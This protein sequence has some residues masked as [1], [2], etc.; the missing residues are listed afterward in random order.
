MRC[1]LGLLDRVPSDFP[2]LLQAHIRDHRQYYGR[3]GLQ[4]TAPNDSLPT[5][6]RMREAR[7]AD[8]IA[9]SMFEQL[10]HVG[11]YL[12]VASG[13]PQPTGS[14]PKSPINLQGIWNQ[15]RRPAW[16]CDLHLDLNLQMCYWPLHAV[17]LGEWF[18]PLMDWAIRLMPQGERAAKDL[19]GCEGI[20]YNASAD[21]KNIGNCDNMSYCWTGSAAWV[22]QVLWEHWEY[23]RNETFLRDRL[24]PFLCKIVRFYEDFLTPDDQGET[25]SV[26][27]R[28]SRDGD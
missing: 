16:D 9:P 1:S 13:R 27:Q 6:E 7:E 20:V 17:N 23:E 2:S 15:D 5:D 19:Y 18:E 26:P 22:A 21:Y 24:Y 10:F 8:T 25:R 11:R 3:V 12:A 4:L 28:F 14:A